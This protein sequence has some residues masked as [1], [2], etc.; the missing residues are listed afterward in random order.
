M[1]EL[2]SLRKLEMAMPYLQAAESSDPKA[3]VSLAAIALADDSSLKLIAAGNTETLTIF[4]DKAYDMPSDEVAALLAGFI[5]GSARF[6]LCLDG[7]EP[8]EVNQI[9]T[10]QAKKTR[11]EKGLPSPVGSLKQQAAT[12]RP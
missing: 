1:S 12:K 9:M 11:E 2:F 5:R 4:Q 8:E 6:K 10:M 7:L 3:L